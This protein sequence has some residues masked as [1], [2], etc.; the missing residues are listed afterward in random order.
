MYSSESEAS[1]SEDGLQDDMYSL[2][3]ADDNDNV[4]DRVTLVTVNE[5]VPAR[6][7]IT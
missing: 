4:P 7:D 2:Q 6:D 5:E 1:E 3:V